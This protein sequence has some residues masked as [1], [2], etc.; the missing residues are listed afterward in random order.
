MQYRQ[1]PWAIFCTKLGARRVSPVRSLTP[2]F[3][4]VAL[5]MWAI[6][7]EIAKIGI[8][9]YKFAKKGY[10]PLSDFYKIWRGGATP[11]PATS[12]KFN[13]CHF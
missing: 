7:A 2:N 3:T 8:F 9:W 11:R 5:K 13:H 10:I 4:I 12:S 1:A 6:G